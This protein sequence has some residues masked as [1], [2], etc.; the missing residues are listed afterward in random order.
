[1]WIGIVMKRFY[2]DG[3]FE[4]DF[5]IERKL[6]SYI[7]EERIFLFERKLIKYFLV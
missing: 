3:G 5:E 1:M 4:L 6:D 2:K 7:W